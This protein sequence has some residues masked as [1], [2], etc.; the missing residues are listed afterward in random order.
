[1]LNNYYVYVYIDP[2][3]MREFYYGKG[4]GERKLSHLKDLE[5]ASEKSSIIK[6]IYESGDEPIIKVVAKGLTEKE[7][8]LV[9]STL[10]WKTGHLL[11][12]K[13]SGHF[14]ERFRPHNT[15]NRNLSGFDF[16]KDI[17]LMNVGD[18]PHRNWHDNQR[19]GYLGAGQGIQF[20]RKIM[21]INPGDIVVAYLSG[22]GY[23]GV[24]RVEAKA[25]P[26]KQFLTDRGIT[27]EELTSPKWNENINNLDC[28]EYCLAIDWV[29]KKGVNNAIER[30]EI[31]YH[32]LSTIVSLSGRPKTLKTLENKFEIC[33]DDLISTNTNLSKAS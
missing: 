4:K 30:K 24:G 26:I 27:R 28:S 11:S 23:V 16:D 6:D 29:V 19:F 20:K 18:G 25:V 8:F 1:M 13:V 32:S 17:F 10:I 7:A 9:E 31:G 14:T 21:K 3:N 33:F 5:K 2:R 22:F 12:N 15:L